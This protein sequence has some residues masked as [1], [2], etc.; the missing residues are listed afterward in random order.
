MS[1]N[2]FLSALKFHCLSPLEQQLVKQQRYIAK[3][4]IQKKD[5]RFVIVI[6][7][8]SIHHHDAALEYANRLKNLSEE[9]N[10]SIAIWMRVFLEKPRTCHG[11]TGYINEENGLTKSRQLLKELVQLQ[12][13]IATEVVNPLHLPYVEEYLSWGFVGARTTQSP[14]H[15]HIASHLDF[16]CG[17]KNT[18]EGQLDIPVQSV[19]AAMQ[20]QKFLMHDG[21]NIKHHHSKGNPYAHVV[22]RGDHHGPNYTNTDYIYHLQKKYFDAPTPVLIDCSHDN[23]QKNPLN[24][25]PIAGEVALNWKKDFSKILGIMVESYI[26]TGNQLSPG[27]DPYLSVT[28]PCL[29]WNQ[30]SSLIRDIYQKLKKPTFCAV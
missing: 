6:G 19:A 26:K 28:D 29:S 18:T 10:D 9:V 15:R 3:Q 30:T 27:S 13:P 11:W 20:Q 12:I 2:C 1:Q 17:F 21:H 5:N 7:P 24:Q 8:C 16:P 4:L 25:I 22:L 23:S 14:I